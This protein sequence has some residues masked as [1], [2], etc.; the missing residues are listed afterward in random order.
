MI[1]FFL[2]LIFNIEKIKYIFW[3]DKY[4]INHIS[5]CTYSNGDKNTSIPVIKQIIVA[6]KDSIPAIWSTHNWS[7]EPVWDPFPTDTQNAI[8]IKLSITPAL[9]RYAI[10]THHPPS[11]IAKPSVVTWPALMSLDQWGARFI[12]KRRVNPVLV[13]CCKVTCIYRKYIS[14]RSSIEPNTR[15]YF[16][17]RV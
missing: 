10:A 4:L 1:F 3:Y 2:F 17:K 5:Y 12:G 8:P 15:P 13:L 7:E 11:A 9:K 14:M 6:G 16:F